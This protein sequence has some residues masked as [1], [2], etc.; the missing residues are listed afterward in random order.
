MCRERAVLGRQHPGQLHSAGNGETGSMLGRSEKGQALVEA[1]L[2]LPLLFSL[3]FGIIEFA[4]LAFSHA[5]IANSARE[6]ARYG[7]THPGDAT[8][9]EAAARSLTS[10]LDQD[11]LQIVST[12]GETMV[13]VEVEYTLDLITGIII[14]AAG[15]QPTLVLHAAASGQ[16]E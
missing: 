4:I 2:T 3:L 13:R 11:S 12:T 6:G 5:T 16:I 10:G 15:G 7:I 9:I 8:G 14:E 1:A